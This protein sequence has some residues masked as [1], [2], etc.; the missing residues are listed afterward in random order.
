MGKLSHR[1]QSCCNKRLSGRCSLK[2][3]SP[4]REAVGTWISSAGLLSE[5]AL[6]PSRLRG[7]THLSTRQSARIVGGWVRQ[8]GLNQACYETHTL[9]RTKGRLIYRRT[10]TSVPCSYCLGTLNSRVPSATLGLRLTMRLKSLNR[11]RCDRMTRSAPGRALTGQLRL[12]TT[13][14]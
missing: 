6:F 5:Q 1:G 11:R 3:L 8:I 9:R 12:L 14:N 7:S 4:T 10:K 2:S 13:S